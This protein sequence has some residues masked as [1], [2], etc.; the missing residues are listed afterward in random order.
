MSM[1][2]MSDLRITPTRR[3]STWSL[4]APEE[5]PADATSRDVPSGRPPVRTEMAMNMAVPGGSFG[6][7]DED[8][9]GYEDDMMAQVTTVHHRHCH[10]Y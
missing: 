10:R 4:P 2:A 8:G 6:G 1:M 7:F 5:T 9:M 3:F